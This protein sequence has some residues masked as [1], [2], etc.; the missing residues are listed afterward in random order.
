MSLDNIVAQISETQDGNALTK[1]YREARAANGTILWEFWDNLDTMSVGDVL[2]LLLLKIAESE[3]RDDDIAYVFSQ[4][5]RA[6]PV[7]EAIKA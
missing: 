6:R 4:L 2:N 3:Y 1:F 7:I 5:Q